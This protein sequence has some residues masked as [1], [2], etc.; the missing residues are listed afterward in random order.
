[1]THKTGMSTVNG[2]ALNTSAAAQEEDVLTLIQEMSAMVGRLSE[3]LRAMREDV[4][5][6]REGQAPA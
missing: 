6:L 5:E 4:A 3:E 1:M 2:N